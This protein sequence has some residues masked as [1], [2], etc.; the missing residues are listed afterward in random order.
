MKIQTLLLLLF[1][2]GMHS[3]DIP[4]G[5]KHIKTIHSTVYKKK[6]TIDYRELKTYYDEDWKTITNSNTLSSALD[7][8]SKTVTVMD[9]KEKFVSAILTSEKDTLDYI[10]YLYD[11][12]GNRTNYYQIRKGDTITDQKRTYDNYGN[13]LELYNRKNGRYYLSF[14]AEYNEHGEVTKRNWY[15]PNKDL[16][17]IEA[18]EY[19]EDG[20][21]ETYYKT[22]KTTELKLQTETEEIAPFTHKKTYFTASEGI[23]YGIKL[24]RKKGYYSITKKN[25]EGELQSFEIFDKRGRLTTSV[26]VIFEDL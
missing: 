26:Y 4:T 24:T 12:A 13:N 19:S 21:T 23:N 20:K 11:D 8:G 17:R 6:D 16:I 3:Q 7:K 9:S 5:T 15:N 22:G 2:I 14:K 1:C 18:F 10:V 25:S